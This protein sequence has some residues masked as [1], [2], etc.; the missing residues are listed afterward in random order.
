MTTRDGLRVRTRG[1][2]GE[3]AVAHVL[4]K[5]DA[6]CARAGA[7]AAEGTLTVSRAKVSRTD[8]PW[9]VT[10]VLL[11]AGSFTVV[12]VTAATAWQAA[13][14]LADQVTAR[15]ARPRTHTPPP[16]RTDAGT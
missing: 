3:E 13:A 11:V 14:R 9:S 7:P 5:L 6:A 16:W 1:E 10:A 4:A 8:R 15:A 12:H 2:V